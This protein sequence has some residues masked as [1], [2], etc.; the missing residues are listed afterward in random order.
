MAPTA[1]TVRTVPTGSGSP[2]GGGPGRA[3]RWSDSL[4][5]V[6]TRR[7]DLRCAY[8][9]TVKDGEPDLSP[10]DALRAIDLFVSR[11]GGGD[12]K[13]FGGEPLLVPAAVEA[14]IRNAP[15]T[16][17]VYLS[18]NGSHLSR[19]WIELLHAHPSVTLT[20]SLDGEP[21]DHDG[22]RR[23]A[24]TYDT[25]TRWLPELLRLP[26]FVVTQTIAPS[27]AA[28]AAAN[29]RH[30]RALGIR[31]FNLL[32]GYYLPWTEAQL[33]ALH[34]SF[35]EIAAHFETAW[36]LGERLYLRNLFVRAPTPFYNTG[37]VVDSDR[38]IY[39][40]NLVLA[41]AFDSLRAAT[42]IGSLDAPPTPERLAEATAAAPAVLE[43]AVGARI[44]ES[45]R[46][47]DAA[48][49]ALCNRLY[50]AYFKMRARA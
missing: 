33:S 19:H 31:R 42:S 23:G 4:I 36:S 27:T 48:L 9:P 28:R 47:A 26:R 18:T 40:N 5:L 50:P 38:R 16:V 8:C 49:T 32:P 37:F 41:G 39:P 43:A 2:R 34:Q 15:P 3:T 17:N 25:V 24:R 45:T 11:H 1:A 7:C 6:L 10:A 35:D 20:V 30:L 46:L 13:L 29:F 44:M 22:L 14:V 12:C 21:G